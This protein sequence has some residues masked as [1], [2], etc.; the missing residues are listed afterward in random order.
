[1][2]PDVRARKPSALAEAIRGTIGDAGAPGGLSRAE[3][4]RQSAGFLTVMT[5]R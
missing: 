2:R 4:Q 3:T 1:M 5:K